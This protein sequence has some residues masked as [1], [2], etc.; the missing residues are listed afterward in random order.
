MYI[1]SCTVAYLRGMGTAKCAHVRG[2]GILD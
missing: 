1:N 2:K